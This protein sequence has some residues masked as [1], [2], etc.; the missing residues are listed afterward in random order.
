[1]EG[2]LRSL[3]AIHDAGIVH[4]DIRLCNIRSFGDR[5]FQLIDYDCSAAVDQTTGEAQVRI[6]HGTTQAEMAGQRVRSL[7]QAE[8]STEVSWKLHDD[9][10]MAMKMALDHWCDNNSFKS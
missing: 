6:E 10:A 2:V 5:G 3:D 7:L 4:C 8:T 9:Y 1:M